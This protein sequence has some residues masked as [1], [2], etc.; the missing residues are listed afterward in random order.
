ML[1]GLN[2]PGEHLEIADAQPVPLPQFALKRRAGGGV[3]GGQLPPRVYHGVR[4]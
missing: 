1:V 4:Y 2:Q 3:A